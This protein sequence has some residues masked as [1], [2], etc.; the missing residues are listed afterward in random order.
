MIEAPN[1]PSKSIAGYP[2][3]LSSVALNEDQSRSLELF[4]VANLADMVD[5]DVLLAG[6]NPPEPPYWALVWIGAKAVADYLLEAPP[7][8]HAR[9]LDLGC[10]LGLSGI[11]AG[12]GGAAITFADIV[13]E[14]LEF[15]RAS[16]EHHRLDSFSTRVVDFTRDRLD[17]SFDLILASDIV[18]APD[19][20]AAL[21]DFIDRHTTEHGTVLLTESL[22]ADAKY[23]THA[24]EA[25]GFVDDVRAT[26]VPDGGKLERTWLHVLTRND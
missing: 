1:N 17:P 12:L 13:P 20:Y 23:V 2:A 15:V 3:E 4:T 6:P 25:R 14:S 16:A 22:R 24:L 11:A 18:Y 8:K 7:P 10:G 5:G 21:V 26:W 9:I 19:D